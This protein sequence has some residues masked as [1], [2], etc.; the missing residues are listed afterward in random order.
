MTVL[1]TSKSRSPRKNPEPPLAITG[2]RGF[3]EFVQA[4]KD[5]SGL[6]LRI[7]EL[8]SVSS[9]PDRKDGNAFCRLAAQ[10]NPQC[11][12]CPLFLNQAD[13]H[14]QT[15]PSTCKCFADIY[16]STI[17]VRIADQT[18]ALLETGYVFLAPPASHSFL[19]VAKS[20]V[21]PEGNLNLME[22]EEAWRTTR[23]MDS[24]QY[25]AFIRMLAAFCRHHEAQNPPVTLP[26][27]DDS[28][29]PP[30]IMRAMTFVEER[31]AEDLS[32]ARVAGVANLSSTYFSKKFAEC[33]GMPFAK[34]VARVRINKASHLL[35]TTNLRIKEIAF[36]SGFKS[37]SQF[38]RVFRSLKGASPGEYRQTSEA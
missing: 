20:L 7:R 29:I 18:S 28:A 3:A 5:A 34:Y 14:T 23:V 11:A 33:A 30:S 37:L 15:E 31:C 9:V 25:L 16:T 10:A 21:D 22:A 13:L 8:G 17:P 27:A 1:K 2:S 12:Q 6:P 24:G 32:L 19:K 35:R 38:N 36:D 4:F 26:A